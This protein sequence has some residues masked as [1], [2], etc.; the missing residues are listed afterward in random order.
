MA[1]EKVS[2]KIGGFNLT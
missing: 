2:A 1:L